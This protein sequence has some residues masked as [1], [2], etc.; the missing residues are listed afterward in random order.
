MSF[1]PVSL[2]YLNPEL[3]AFS[4]VIT[5]E[6]ARDFH[7]QGLDAGLIADESPIPKNF[8]ESVYISDNKSRM[9]VSQLNKTIRQAML[10]DGEALE[11]LER[12]GRYYTTIYRKAILTSTNRFRFND[13]GDLTRFFISES[14]LNIG[15]WIKI[16]KNNSDIMYARVTSI[17]DTQS[18]TISNQ[19]YPF[20]DSNAETSY[21]VQGIKLYDSARLARISFMR[22][23]AA[24]QSTPP[25]SGYTKVDTNFNYELYKILYPDARLLN[26]EAAFIDYVN[27][28]KNNDVRIARTFDIKFDDQVL[29][30]VDNT[31]ALR[32]TNQ[33]WLDF[34]GNDGRVTWNN[35]NLYYCTT[36]SN[37]R[38]YQ[39]PADKD[40]L[41]TERAIKGYVDSFLNQR[42]TVNNLDVVGTVSF[43]SNVSLTGNST[44]ITNAAITTLTT[45]GA[46][47]MNGP[48]TLNGVTTVS[49]PLTVNSTAIFNNAASFTGAVTLS[50]TLT[51]IKPTTLSDAL[52]VNGTTVIN[53]PLTI[54]SNVTVTA[55]STT[56]NSELIVNSNATF[57]GLNNVF[58]GQTVT[59]NSAV[60]H[61]GTV[62]FSNSAKFANSVTLE[63]PMTLNSTMALN[64]SVTMASNLTLTNGSLTLMSGDAT[65]GKGLTVNSNSTL[66]G[67]LTVS[68][69]TDL[70]ALKI[71]GT[72]HIAS[73]IS[74]SNSLYANQVSAC[75]IDTPGAVTSYSNIS[76]YLNTSNIYAKTLS[77]DSIDTSLLHLS[78]VS[79]CTNIYT[80]NLCSTSL[81][82][83]S[84]NI[85]DYLEA[86]N[87]VV[88][89]SITTMMINSSNI[90]ATSN[91][92]SE[93]MNVNILY[94][95]KIHS[96]WQYNSNYE[97]ESN[98]TIY[99]SS[100]NL[101]SL[102]STIYESS[103]SNLHSSNATITT[104]TTSNLTSSNVFASNLTLYSTLKVQTAHTFSNFM[105]NLD[106]MDL[107]NVQN[108]ANIDELHVRT[109][110]I[111]N[112]TVDS[113]LHAN[114][115][116]DLAG[117]AHFDS[118]LDVD[119]TITS[120]IYMGSRIGI[121]DY[122]V[123]HP[124]PMAFS[125]YILNNL[126][127]N[128]TVKTEGKV[129]IGSTGT[130]SQTMLEVNG[131]IEA[132]NI[133]VTSDATLKKEVVSVKDACEMLS[134]IDVVEYKYR[135]KHNERKRYGVIAQNLEQAVPEAV[136]QMDKYQIVLD[137]RCT[138][139][140]QL[141]STPRH[142]LYQDEII[143]IV[144]ESET[145]VVCKVM[146]VVSPDSFQIDQ[147]L[148]SN[149]CIL[150]RILYSNIKT[151]DY[152]QICALLIKAVQQLDAKIDKLRSDLVISSCHSD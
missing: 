144:T 82:K 145:V 27:R 103:F 123:L 95:N 110:S 130:R 80:S 70:Q 147:T 133:D 119:G 18:F 142:G 84:S 128:E 3:Q 56:L 98:S 21:L 43:T 111:S 34:A 7:N 1:N 74:C 5:V 4:N 115:D 102:S 117:N 58:N 36:D 146:Q 87:L 125:N 91:I 48:L 114:G 113:D 26:R 148:D 124:L 53:A 131:L 118:N 127:V 49:Q 140:G 109:T 107:L 89:S 46:A 105:S 10:N 72:L 78:T 65:L 8:D 108:R 136:D 120:S 152:H 106:V 19:L 29:N 94:V 67:D 32:I 57:N 97:S 69:I 17:L 12:D 101:F 88:N 85:G 30:V 137:K 2:L 92:T 9:D 59:Y 61:Q 63:S 23:W 35:L 71:Q 52:T 6:Q 54:N 75:N 39:I 100:S 22:N 132:T 11:S 112:L 44:G 24:N 122:T 25:T 28:L 31:R 38:A 83:Y 150:H 76:T 138:A 73:N 16:V 20:T 62:T 141:I 126:V 68:G 51:V 55:P 86:S 60:T 42:L 81:I 47:T 37:R 79:N 66:K 134:G 99:Q 116:F 13:A 104:I 15:D 90:K 50:N 139:N 121:S 14:N 45:S 151:V 129:Q 40:G 33:L 135:H 143:E 41:I 149:R 96:E 64:D 77:N 93:Y